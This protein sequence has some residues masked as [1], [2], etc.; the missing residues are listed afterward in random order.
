MS[1]ITKT[2]APKQKKNVGS[3]LLG[4]LL[5][6][7]CAGILFLPIS[8]FTSAWVVEQQTLI[9][10][11]QDILASEVKMFGM[12]P[13]FVDGTGFLAIAANV[14]LY[15]FIL[16]IAVAAI[17]S[18]IAIFSKKGAPGLVRIAMFLVVSS[19]FLQTLSIL[20]ISNYAPNAEATT[21][22][23]T[24]VIAGV[25][26]F[27]YFLLA[28]ARNGKAAWLT[29]VHFLLSLTA[30]LLIIVALMKADYFALAIAF[31][32]TPIY[33]IVLIAVVVLALLNLFISACRAMSKKGLSGD[34]VRH[35]AQLVVALV[36]CF[37]GHAAEIQN[38]NYVLFCVL[39]AIVSAVQIIIATLQL[40]DRS[41]KR[42]EAA[43]EAALADFETEEYV[44]TYAYAGG[45]VAG[46]E[47]AEEITPTMAA[48]AAAADGSK[49]NLATLVGN[50]FDAFMFNLSDKEKEDFVDLYIVRCKGSMPEIPAYVVG[51]D[52]REF[53]NKVFI[54]LGQYREKIPSGLLS[55]M[56]NFSMKLS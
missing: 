39:A 21:D 22:L 55:K 41:K 40:L 26:A 33:R 31:A 30:S 10:S 8:T 43:T 9:Q 6:A 19:A 20:A 17:C 25:G 42:G 35:V 18:L 44:E 5:L 11:V 7:V 2:E 52:N 49:P 29:A 51:G 45:P 15:F 54:Y 3:R 53:F 47:L 1:K 48:A 38:D 50:G 16:A 23:W 37:V 13:V 46:V 28:L 27:I 32:E 12:I 36:A 14:V 24:M 34:I 4:L 56:Y